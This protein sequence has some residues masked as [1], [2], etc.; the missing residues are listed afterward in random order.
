MVIEIL[1][2]IVLQT[3]VTEP[4]HGY[5]QPVYMNCSHCKRKA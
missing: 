1:I 2:R 3:G 4:Y 5:G